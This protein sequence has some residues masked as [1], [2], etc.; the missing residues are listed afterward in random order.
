GY[1]LEQAYR[2][3]VAL[4]PP[5][6]R[7]LRLGARAVERLAGAGQRAL[8]GG[9]MS[10]AVKLLTR[11]TGLLAEDDFARVRILPDL[12]RALMERGELDAAGTVIGSAIEAAEAVGDRRTAA[13]ALLERIRLRA[14]IKSDGW[15]EEARREARN[16]MP[17]F[18]ELGDDRGLAR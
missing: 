3:S 15:A 4:H 14:T 6:E 5:G 11:S 18:E 8:D 16:L 9:N 7:E 1:H 12:G 2:T 17:L 13:Y 10:V